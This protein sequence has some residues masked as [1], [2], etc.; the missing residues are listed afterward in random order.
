MTQG[1]EKTK[2]ILPFQLT[3]AIN[4]NNE[5]TKKIQA[6]YKKYSVCTKL[7]PKHVL[8][9]EEVSLKRVCFIVNETFGFPCG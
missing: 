7:I 9:H 2:R 1:T 8:W 4:T 3:N 5:S 6:K